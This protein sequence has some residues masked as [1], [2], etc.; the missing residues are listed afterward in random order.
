MRAPTWAERYAQ[1]WPAP[2]RHSPR[3]QADEGDARCA[4]CAFEAAEAQA[5]ADYLDAYELGDD[6]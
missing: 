4:R 2:P 3:C 1:G 5:L 6:S